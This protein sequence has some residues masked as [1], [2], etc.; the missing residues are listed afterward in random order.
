V[1]QDGTHSRV[2]VL[3]HDRGGAGRPSSWPQYVDAV[4][5]YAS[6][7]DIGEIDV[8]DRI[9]NNPGGWTPSNGT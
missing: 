1:S 5:L 9:L 8:S 4:C 7:H 2:A 3:A 6:L